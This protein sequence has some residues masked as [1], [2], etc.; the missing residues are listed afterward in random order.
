MIFIAR[1]SH[2][3]KPTPRFRGPRAGP[4]PTRDA[5]FPGRRA[6][7]RMKLS[8]GVEAPA[9]P[10]RIRAP[11]ARTSLSCHEHGCTNKGVRKSAAL[12]SGRGTGRHVGERAQ[13]GHSSILRLRNTGRL[14][15]QAV[16]GYSANMRKQAPP[17]R[18]LSATSSSS[19]STDWPSLPL[20]EE[21]SIELQ[22]MIGTVAS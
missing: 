8:R 18:A 11:S 14:R 3:R 21:N 10:P 20:M 5:R 22:M 17:Y 12:G 1:S 15:K 2:I 9:R 7:L 4:L 13:T 6:A 19:S 16:R